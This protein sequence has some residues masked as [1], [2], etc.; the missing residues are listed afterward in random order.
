MKKRKK[1]KRKKKKKE[2]INKFYKYTNYMDYFSEDIDTWTLQE[3]YDTMPS[4]KEINKMSKKEIFKMLQEKNIFSKTNR[5]E[6][7]EQFL[8]KINK[9]S[10]LY[11]KKND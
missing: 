11:N 6:D 1:R 10:T 5:L 3:N 4:I 2:N 7:V 8:Y 9:D